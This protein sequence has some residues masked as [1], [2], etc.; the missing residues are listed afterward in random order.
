MNNTLNC[1]VSVTMLKLS[2]S[3]W[4]KR[5]NTY[6]ILYCL[7]GSSYNLMY[8]QWFKTTRLQQQKQ[9]H[10]HNRGKG[11]GRKRKRAGR[12]AGKR[13]RRRW[14]TS[15]K[16]RTHQN[17]LT[18]S[19]SRTELSVCGSRR[20]SCRAWM[21]CGWQAAMSSTACSL[22]RTATISRWTLTST[23]LSR[24]ACT[25][26]PSCS[27]APFMH[28]ISSCRGKDCNKWRWEMLLNGTA[29]SFLLAISQSCQLCR[30]Y[31][32]VCQLCPSYFM[33]CQ[34]C[35]S[36]F[37]VCQLCRSYFMVCQLCPSYFPVCQLCRFLQS[38]NCVLVISVNC[39]LVISQ[40]VNCVLAISQFVNCVLATS[41][42][43]SFSLLFDSQ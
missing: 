2:I 6:P 21:A 35:P 7:I 15:D 39:V 28:C 24:C 25:S 29:I 31:F 3:Q 11:G 13:K 16:R 42:S 40:F 37:M 10:N 1:A 34:L 9:Q 14:R 20:F 5:T 33:V 27:R 22:G 18:S 17:V 4:I 23:W 43:V 12:E 26:T 32:M 19:A 8:I 41:K 30:S 36:Y 38:V